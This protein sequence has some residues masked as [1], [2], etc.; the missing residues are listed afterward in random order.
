MIMRHRRNGAFPQAQDWIGERG[1]LHQNIDATPTADCV[2]LSPLAPAS[3]VGG[4][5]N[6]R[7]TCGRALRSFGPNDARRR[8]PPMQPDI[9]F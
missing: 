3:M 9:R 5:D 1:T 8:K 4:M 6:R 2:V 7:G